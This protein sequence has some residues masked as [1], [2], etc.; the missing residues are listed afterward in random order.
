M[1]K[2]RET[3]CSYLSIFFLLEEIC[4]KWLWISC[5]LHFGFTKPI[6]RP[7]EIKSASGIYLLH[8]MDVTQD[9]LKG[10]FFFFFLG[11]FCS[12]FYSNLIFAWKVWNF[13]LLKIFTIELQ[14][15]FRNTEQSIKTLPPLASV[16]VYKVCRWYCL[17][18][19]CTWYSM[20]PVILATKGLFQLFWTCLNELQEHLQ[21][22]K[23][24]NLQMTF[25]TENCIHR[26]SIKMQMRTL[27]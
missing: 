20:P 27:A 24:V 17:T 14:S 4:I 9:M 16:L 12:A 21:C 25:G 19:I 26:Y 23:P 8:N 3:I 10:D 5:T 13:T 11:K 7:S 18:R 22:L 6:K 1:Q 2:V 15:L